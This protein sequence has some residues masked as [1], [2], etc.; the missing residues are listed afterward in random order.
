M[1]GILAWWNWEPSLF[2]DVAG[3]GSQ[4]KYP[5]PFITLCPTFLLLTGKCWTRSERGRGDP[6]RS[7]ALVFRKGQEDPKAGSWP[8]MVCGH[9]QLS[10]VFFPIRQKPSSLIRPSREI[11][12]AL[13]HSK[14]FQAVV[15]VLFLQICFS[16]GVPWIQLCAKKMAQQYLKQI[17]LYQLARNLFFYFT[18]RWRCPFRHWLRCS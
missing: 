14:F 11:P 5:G 10:R 7:V 4:R 9:D 3:E 8:C 6:L 17:I 12:S 16:C 15:L 2:P 18:I 13:K 1:N